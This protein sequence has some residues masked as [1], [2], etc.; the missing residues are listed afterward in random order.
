[1]KKFILL[2][3]LSI[4]FISCGQKEGRIIEIQEVSQGKFVVQDERNADSDNSWVVVHYLNGN[5]R[6]I[7]IS[8]AEQLMNQVPPSPANSQV[9]ANYD[10]GHNQSGIS[11]SDL[12]LYHMMFGGFGGSHYHTQIVHR[13]P[14]YHTTIHKTVNVNYASNYRKRWSATQFYKSNNS[15]FNRYSK[16][17]SRSD[18]S[19]SRIMKTK[20]RAYYYPSNS[21]SY[22]ARSSSSSSSRKSSFSGFRRKRK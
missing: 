9:F 16:T 18:L 10:G 2:F 3:L 6:T 20:A 17:Y 15:S 5:Q 14:V 11:F 13:Y 12:M 22:V 4:A 7:G 21:S 1:M 8:E 19:N